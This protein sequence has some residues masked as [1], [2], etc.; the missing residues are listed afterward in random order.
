[1]KKRV[2]E[3]EFAEKILYLCVILER[4]NRMDYTKLPRYFIYKDRKD[5]DE[6][7]VKTITPQHERALASI[8]KKA[9]DGFKTMDQRMF[10]AVE[11]SAIVRLDGARQYVC[12]IFNTAHYI[13]TL[14]LMDQ[15]P[16]LNFRTYL[17]RADEVAA[18]HG[19]KDPNHIPLQGM[20]MALVYNYLCALNPRYLNMIDFA[21][22]LENHFSSRFT[23]SESI[24]YSMGGIMDHSVAQAILAE[25]L[26]DRNML[27][28]KECHSLKIEIKDFLPRPIDEVLPESNYADIYE[29]LDYI[30]ECMKKLPPEKLLDA[31]KLAAQVIRRTAHEALQGAMP[32]AAKDVRR[33]VSIALD[34]LGVPGFP[35][36]LALELEGIDE[37]EE[38]PVP[39]SAEDSSEK[40]RTIQELQARLKEMEKK[41]ADMQQKLD[42][43]KNLPEEVEYWRSKAESTMR[44]HDDEKAVLLLLDHFKKEYRQEQ[45]VREF[46]RQI[47]GMTDGEIGDFIRGQRK[48]D[49]KLSDKSQLSLLWRT[50]NIYGYYQSSY[51]NFTAAMRKS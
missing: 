26:F 13:T 8:G 16:M 46:L 7:D 20:T 34:R 6:Y 19:R 49:G 3:E 28:P 37:T 32:D 48:S 33:M 42:N 50:L 31:P 43:C 29:H 35:E 39:E 30:E 12:D 23:P 22:N 25:Q 40:D 38:K 45:V 11:S 41:V 15:H 21:E 24:S 9:I 14:I 47:Q 10:E 51:Q 27:T 5:I 36:Q 18:E 1:M 4:K 17:D 44:A 2:P